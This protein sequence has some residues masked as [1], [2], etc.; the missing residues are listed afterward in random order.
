MNID[1]AGDHPTFALTHRRHIDCEAV[2]RD[3]ELRTPSQVRGERL[4]EQR[5]RPNVLRAVSH[6]L[7]GIYDKS[8][9]LSDAAFLF[10]TT[11]HLTR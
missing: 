8:R 11:T 3:A 10:G 4:T 9:V 7:I 6:Q 5:R 2:N 1:R